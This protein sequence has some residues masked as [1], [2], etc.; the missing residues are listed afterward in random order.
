MSHPL[1]LQQVVIITEAIHNPLYFISPTVVISTVKIVQ[2]YS[3]AEKR[4]FQQDID[5]VRFVS[6]NQIP[7]NS[8]NPNNAIWF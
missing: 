3:R 8:L 2:K 4:L 6:L 1:T 5:H 7:E